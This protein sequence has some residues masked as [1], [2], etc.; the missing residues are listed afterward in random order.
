MGAEGSLESPPGD[1]LVFRFLSSGLV[2]FTLFAGVLLCFRFRFKEVVD[3]LRAHSAE[4]V[5]DEHAIGQRESGVNEQ[6]ID[7]EVA[8]LVPY[9]SGRDPS[10][11]HDGAG[12]GA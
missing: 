1:V 6:G 4:A 8:S 2:V 12:P 9:A 10:G 5:V 7:G 11:A 3:L